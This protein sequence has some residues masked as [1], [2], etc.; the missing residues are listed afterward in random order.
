[1]WRQDVFALRVPTH[2]YHQ[3]L[4]D[5]IRPAMP[6]LVDEPKYKRVTFSV[7][8]GDQLNNLQHCTS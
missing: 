7:M 8:C 3:Y 1:M 5:A 4:S 2:E 6:T